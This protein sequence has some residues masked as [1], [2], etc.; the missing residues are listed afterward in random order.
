[1]IRV[2]LTA[3]AE[4]ALADLDQ[5][6]LDMHAQL[7]GHISETELKTLCRLLEKVRDPLLDDVPWFPLA[8]TGPASDA[9]SVGHG[10]I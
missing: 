8:P 7:L 6:V 3:K 1:M 4:K 2:A 9:G 5:P 10:G